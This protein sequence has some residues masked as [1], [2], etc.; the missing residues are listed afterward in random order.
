M[1]GLSKKLSL[2]HGAVVM[3]GVQ[4]LGTLLMSFVQHVWVNEPHEIL[5]TCMKG[6]RMILQFNFRLCNYLL[7]PLE[8]SFCISEY[9]WTTVHPE[10]VSVTWT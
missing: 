3:A 10:L 6:I 9:F 4:Q 8:W 1:S 5:L 7:S 2:C